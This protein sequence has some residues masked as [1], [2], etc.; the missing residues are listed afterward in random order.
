MKSRPLKKRDD[1]VYA[2]FYVNGTIVKFKK[3]LSSMR[4]VGVVVKSTYLPFPI[5]YNQ[6][7]WPNPLHPINKG[8]WK[9]LPNFSEDKKT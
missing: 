3:D 6:G 1:F 5:G 4:I 9:I 8:M 2:E 7:V